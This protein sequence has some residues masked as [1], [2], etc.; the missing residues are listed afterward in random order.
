MLLADLV[1]IRFYQDKY[2]PFVYLPVF[3]FNLIL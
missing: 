1:R 2:V 3:I